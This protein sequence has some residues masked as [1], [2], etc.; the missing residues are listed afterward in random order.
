[1]T[2]SIVNRC[3]GGIARGRMKE[4]MGWGCGHEDKSGRIH[5]GFFCTP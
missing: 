2:K 4:D 1:M 3:I 5:S